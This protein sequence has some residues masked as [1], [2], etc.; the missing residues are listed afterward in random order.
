[1]K[2]ISIANLAKKYNIKAKKELGQ[3]FIFDQNITDKML[4]N[5]KDI[6]NKHVIEIGPGTGALTCSILNK[7][8]KK[9]TA[10]EFDQD[11]MPLLNE[12]FRHFPDVDKEIMQ[13]DALNFNFSNFD[14]FSIIANLPYNIATPLIFKWLEIA[15]QVDSITIMIQKEV[16][17]RIAA[18]PR[19]KAYGRLSVMCQL[20]CEV[21]SNFI[22]KPE[23]FNPPPKIDSTVITLTPKYN[24]ELLPYIADISKIVKLA[25][26][27]RRKMLRSVL[28]ESCDDIEKMLYSIN[29]APTSRAEELNIIDFINLYKKL[30]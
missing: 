7:N 30:S 20:F 11:F 1:M 9:Y 15:N 29:I 17:E 24:F 3:N 6:A 8:P 23:S 22:V 13:A 2:S 26:S 25:F 10:I 27:Q 14:K 12:I 5:I 28:K 21:K 19:T 18:K 16:A 4:S